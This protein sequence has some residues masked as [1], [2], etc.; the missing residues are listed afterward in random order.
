[1]K[2][3]GR[4]G[5][6]SPKALLPAD[7]SAPDGVEFRSSAVRRRGL[8]L[9]RNSSFWIVIIDLALVGVFGLLQQSF[10]SGANLQSLALDASEIVLL[11]AGEAMLLGAAE[12]DI[13]LGANLVLASVVGGSVMVALAGSP[14]QVASGHYPHVGIAI[15][16]GVLSCVVVGTAV[17]GVNGWIVTRLRVNSLIAT[18]ATFGIASGIADIITNGGNV[19]F[20]PSAIQT[21]FGL[22]AL[23]GVV[24]LPAIV[25]LIALAA[26]WFMYNRTRFG[27][28]ALALGSSREAAVRAGLRVRWNV[29]RLFIVA[30]FFAGVAGLI[31]LAR[32]GTTDVG[33]H[34]NDALAAIAGAVIGGAALSGGR[35]S[36]GGAIAGAFI[37]VI[38][39]SGLVMV[40][41]SAFYQLI[42]VGVILLGAVYLD[43]RRQRG[44]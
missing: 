27:V 34:A 6:R 16:I 8:R 3:I 41:L 7:D 38:L 1:M 10:V 22:A 29:A 18:L 24:P 21:G 42:A 39:E 30:G 11:A 2:S 26:V 40:G 13:S 43:Q 19:P 33:G 14:R 35:A 23:G 32:F 5:P 15:A 44:T 28:H 31:D 12:F 37:S 9:A 25:S 36:I 20:V 17:G 4:S